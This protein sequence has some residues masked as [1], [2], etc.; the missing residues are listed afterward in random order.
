MVKIEIHSILSGKRFYEFP[1][2]EQAQKFLEEF[3]LDKVA[4]G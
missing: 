2:V 4:K 3:D 1:S